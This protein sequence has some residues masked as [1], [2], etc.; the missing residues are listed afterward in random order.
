M[1]TIQVVLDEDLLKAADK[2]A[3]QQNVNRSALLREALRA[4][5]KNLR[6]RELEE[7]EKRG[8]QA[9]PDTLDDW[10]RWERVA[11]WPE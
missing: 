9:K 4:H 10:G 5:L 8:Y 2:V 7:R 6:V 3:K 11:A 1:A